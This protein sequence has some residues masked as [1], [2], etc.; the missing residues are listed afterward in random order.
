VI[1]GRLSLP[2]LVLCYHDIASGTD[3]VTYLSVSAREFERQIVTLRRRGYRP[4]LARD[5]ADSDR[6]S[7]CVTFDDGYASVATTAAPILSTLGVPATVFVITEC[8]GGMIGAPGGVIAPA[9][10]WS[11][12]RELAGAGWEIGSHSVSHKVLPLESEQGAWLELTDS[13]T[14]VE[15]RIGAE[16]SSFAYPYGR[17]D[18]TSASKAREAGYKNAFV[19]TKRLGRDER[20]AYPRVAVLGGDGRFRFAIKTIRLGR[21]ARATAV[22]SSLFAIFGSSVSKTRTRA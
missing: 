22:G 9:L 1:F 2:N 7:F 6:A 15:S 4:V 5:I 12:L 11:Q 16:C 19:L 8:I 14:A 13:K 20:F 18:P 10:T 21:A 3:P 17:A